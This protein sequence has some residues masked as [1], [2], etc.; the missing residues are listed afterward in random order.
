MYNTGNRLYY[1]LI[2]SKSLDGVVQS[3]IELSLLDAFTATGTT[4]N[5]ITL[6]ELSLYSDNEYNMRYAAFVKYINDT[7][8]NGFENSVLPVGN[9]ADNTCIP[10]TV[11]VP[12]TTIYVPTTTVYVP[13]LTTTVYIPTTTINNCVQISEQLG[14]SPVSGNDACTQ[15]R[16]TY[17]GNNSSFSLTT[18]IS[19]SN[20]CTVTLG[21]YYS[22]GYIWKYTADGMN[23][24]SGGTCG[25]PAT[26][27]APLPF[28]YNLYRCDNSQYYN[29]GPY[30]GTK[31]STG[32]RV[33]GATGVFYVV[34]GTTNVNPGSVISGITDTGLMGC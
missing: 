31:L 5:T 33:E 29:A 2:I 23:F 22:N 32:R 30:A 11:Y 3:V 24:I 27:L 14:W 12:T 17:F 8:Y 25:M 10:T 26:T 6:N 9:F 4:Y 16:D 19:A 18:R 15:L 28:W 21:G 20:S 1:K 7:Y 34:V 13:P